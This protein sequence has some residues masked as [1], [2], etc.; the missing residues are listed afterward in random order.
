MKSKFALL[1]MVVFCE[2]CLAGGEKTEVQYL[3]GRGKDDGVK[4]KFYCSGGRNSGQWTTIDVPSCWEL[5]G[6][7]N[8]NYG[9]DGMKQGK[10]RPAKLDE[11]GKYK[12]NFKVSSK[13]ESKRVYIFFDGVMTDAEVKVN[14]K[15]AGAVHQG[16][17]YQFKYDVT[18][19]L[20]YGGENLLEVKVS[21]QSANASVN[22]AERDA[23]YWVFGGIFR[24]V[25]LKAYP[26]EFIERVAI[27]AKS[28]GGFLVDV[29]LGGCRGGDEV[30][31]E[32]VGADGKLD[33]SDMS[34]GVLAG[35]EKVTLGAKCSGQ[36]NW[37]AETPELYEVRLQLKRGG[38][39]L[40]EVR[41]KFGF[42]T[43]EVK[44]GDGVYL[45]GK[46]I[47]I[48][49]VNRHCFWPDSGRTTSRELSVEDIKLIKEM[50]M[51]AVRMSH[52]PPDSHFLEECDRLGLYVLDE[53]GGWGSWSGECYDTAVGKKLVKE[54][55]ERDVCHPCV[56]FWDNGNEGGWNTE[57]D[58]EFAKHDS[59]GRA[60]LHPGA[61]IGSKHSI[62]D[63]DVE[64]YIPY[65]KL[66]KKIDAGYLVM[67][68]ELLHGLYDGGH[69]AGLDD[70]WKLIYESET[71]VGAFMWAF[72][73]E[74]VV[75]GDKGGLID[76]DLDH[77][78]DGIV[79]PKHEKEGSFYTIKEIFSPVYIGMEKL[80]G[81]FDGKMC[82]ENR[83]DFS[84][85]SECGFSWKLI[86]FPGPGANRSMRV[87]KHGKIASPDV[88]AK[89]SGELNL[90]LPADWRSADALYLTARDEDGRE[91]WTWSW[92]ISGAEDYS[93]RYVKRGSGKV[94]LM[95]GALKLGVRAGKSEF[96]F[97]KNSGKLEKVRVEGKDISF[98]NGPRLIGGE[99]KFEKM[100][101][102]FDGGA[103][104]VE[105]KYTGDMNW[106]K[107]SI[108][109]SGWVKLEYEYQMSGKFDIMGVDFDYPEGRMKGMRLVG[110]GP[111]RV[112]KN[113]S[114]GGLIGLWE[115][116]YFDD[117][118]AVTWRYP[119]FKGYYGDFKWVEFATGQGVITAV[120]EMDGL[121]LG[122]YTPKDGPWPNKTKLE[123]ADTQIAFLHGVPAIGTKFHKAEMLGPESEKNV[124][125]GVYEG[126][127][128]F[129]F[130]R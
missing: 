125:D 34:A 120:A 38:Q 32:I 122:V 56:I 44:A 70:Y 40:H 47:K 12:Y 119:E 45:N 4:W 13:W 113:R 104:V 79:G 10:G 82:V 75:R 95:D 35:G 61:R 66:V 29:Y 50:N 11:H 100:R 84:N 55:V 68:T 69:G 107:W 67:P 22:L 129:R 27:D 5:K 2:S 60:V 124:A 20:N 108:W 7:G 103:L 21:K 51:N 126:A 92:G 49:G 81:D 127:V 89:G 37:S 30:S 114:K 63:I 102:W 78:P 118:P 33:G 116:E 43:V 123:A 59:Q 31:A 94:E 3:S 48:K 117:T 25:Y 112:W 58:G 28:D 101:H 41:Q 99:S 46:K 86:K 110:N 128:Y 80:G 1:L 71:G 6:F 105:A 83:Y 36:R 18:K 90:K 52:Y 26:E 65:E 53:L 19:L 24:P 8:Y 111:F 115:N 76:V 98:N 16:A 39:V 23:D 64:H 77:G 88:E 106:V 96:V 73:D 9:H 14:G 72:A 109:P 62:G 87:F 54:M 91:I 85:L 17:F 42:R 74:G 15:K 97:G 130:E 57:L 93:R 121:Y